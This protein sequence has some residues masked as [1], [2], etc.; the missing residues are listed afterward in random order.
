MTRGVLRL[1]TLGGEH[2][3]KV[4][5]AFRPSRLFSGKQKLNFKRFLD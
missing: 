5:E 4:P 3:L 2:F 1:C